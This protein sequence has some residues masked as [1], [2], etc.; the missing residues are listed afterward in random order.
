MFACNI[1]FPF[2]CNTVDAP[3][4]PESSISLQADSVPQIPPPDNCCGCGFMTEDE[5]TSLRPSLRL[6]MECKFGFCGRKC[7]LYNENKVAGWLLFW[8]IGF[9]AGCFFIADVF[10]GVHVFEIAE[11]H[12]Q[13]SIVFT[14]LPFCLLACGL[15]FYQI[16]THRNNLVHP[17]SQKWV[18]R[19][20]W[21][22]PI[23]AFTSWCSMIFLRLGIYFEFLRSIYEA[24]VLYSFLLLLTKYVGGHKGAVRMIEEEG[25]LLTEFPWPF[26][27]CFA[28]VKPDSAFLWKLKYSVMQYTVVVPICALVT[29]ITNYYDVYYN[30]SFRLDGGYTYV[31]FFIN[32]S[33]MIALYGLVWMYVVLHKSLE[34]FNPMHKFLVVKAVVFFTFWQSI[35]LSLL[36]YMGFFTAFEVEGDIITQEEIQVGFQ[37]FLIC[38]EMFVAALFHTDTFGFITYVNGEYARIMNERLEATERMIAEQAERRKQEAAEGNAE[39]HNDEEGWMFADNYEG[40]SASDGMFTA[41]Y[42]IAK[43]HVGKH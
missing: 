43:T 37:N 11:L 6:A 25:Q 3:K 34:P 40:D 42:K 17:K 14:A 30:G 38:L 7:M 9:I 29:L 26:N 12:K 18:V 35:G 36:G 2:I 10:A 5:L 16:F 41:A 28:P 23:Y 21:M 20:I 8:V 24:Y 39:E 15:S 27:K 19:I 13:A 1:Y 31:S 22:V 32:N 4:D 33:Q